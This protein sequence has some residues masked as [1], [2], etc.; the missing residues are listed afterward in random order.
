MTPPTNFILNGCLGM[1]QLQG[2]PTF[3]WEGETFNCI[4]N[5]IK[6]SEIN[7]SAGLTE[8]TDFRM[9][10]RLNQFTPNIYPELNDYIIYLGYQLLIRGINKPAHGV[11]WIYICSMPTINK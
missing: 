6:D 7:V 2:S 3:I 11:F 1:E 10:V 9:T 4:A 5:T 8:N